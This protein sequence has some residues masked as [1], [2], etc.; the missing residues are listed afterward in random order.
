MKFSTPI[1]VTLPPMLVIPTTGQPSQPS[2]TG[3]INHISTVNEGILVIL[4][5][6]SYICIGFGYKKYQKKRATTQQERLKTLER[7]WKLTARTREIDSRE[8]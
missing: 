4:F 8:H 5:F 1:N 7:I 6:L 3:Q 2:S